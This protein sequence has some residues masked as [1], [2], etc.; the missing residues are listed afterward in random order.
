MCRSAKNLN[1]LRELVLQAMAL[2]EEEE[3]EGDEDEEVT[4][5]NTP[6]LLCPPAT[7]TPHTATFHAP[8]SIHYPLFY[9]VDNIPCCIL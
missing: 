3:Q 8:Q 5:Q 2:V 1:V 9:T 6:T 4:C 7:Q